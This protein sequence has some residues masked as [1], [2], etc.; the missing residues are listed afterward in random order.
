MRDDMQHDTTRDPRRPAAAGGLARLDDL[1]DYKVADGEPDIRGWDVKTADGRRIGEVKELLVDTGAMKVR[2]MEVELD[3]KAS[4]LADDRRIL[5]PIGTA[6]LDDDADDVYV[7][8]TS[9][10]LATMPAYDRS[11]FGRD[12]E[13]SLR[14][15][16]SAGA[17]GAA[18]TTRPA[19]LPAAEPDEGFYGHPVYDDSRFFGSRRKG[20]ERDAYFRRT[21]E[22]GA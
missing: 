10:D 16:Y 4:G 19:D 3:R 20:R 13:T 6:R 2:Y 11:A 7:Q 9:A 21:G 8:S 1:D 15:R 18:G 22:P 5:V 12:Y 17:A 14:D